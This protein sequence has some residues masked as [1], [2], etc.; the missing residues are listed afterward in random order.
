M[1]LLLF[2]PLL[3]FSPGCKKS[4]GAPNFERPPALVSVT[5]AVAQDVPVYLQEI[6]RCAA[7]EMVTV[8]PQVSGVLMKIHF[9]DGADLKRGDPLFTIDPRPYQAQLDLAE[10]NLAQNQ[11]TLD[12][13][14][15]EFQRA[16]QLLPGH[17]ISRQEYDQY[18]LGVPIAAARAASSRA[19]VETARLNLE[20]CSICSPIEGRAGQRLVDVGNVVT[21]PM[22]GMATSLL[23]IQRL[24]PIYADFI[25]TEND[26]SAVQRHM[27]A[28]ALQADVWL[29]DAPQESRRGAVT[30]LD[31]AVQDATGTVKLRATL[32]NADRRFWPGRFVKVRLILSMQ[33]GAV[34]IPAGAP[35]PSASGPFVYVVNDKSI[36]ELRPVALGQRHG[37]L[38]VIEKGLKAGER[39]V[40]LGQMAV[41]PGGP[42]AVAPPQPQSGGAPPD[43]PP[44]AATG[45]KS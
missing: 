13:A 32:S 41:V 18:K 12:L 20:Y 29:P 14:K 42:V 16:E 40:T 8:Q 31:N 4:Q 10:A 5:A 26:L 39:V 27:K 36:A 2:L 30:F 6:G 23:V 35:Q 28:G 45:G 15:L 11:A 21:S 37:D 7:R 19:A 34:L 22:L 44:A 3:A 24:D 38:V 9:T 25:V 43:K 33:K 17:A 1:C